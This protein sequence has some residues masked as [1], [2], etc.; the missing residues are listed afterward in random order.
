MSESEKIIKVENWGDVALRKFSFQDKC[1]LRGKI[2]N[3]TVDPRTNK[4]ETKID[5]SAIF[6]WTTLLSL[7]SMPDHPNFYSYPLEKKHE[8]LNNPEIEPFLTELMSEAM[9][10]NQLNIQAVGK[11]NQSGDEK[12]TG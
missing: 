4:E 10:Y 1:N 3:I 5:S 8:V 7:K 2:V 9:A 12:A 6:Y 11:K